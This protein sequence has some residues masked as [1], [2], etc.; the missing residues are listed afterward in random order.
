[1]AAEMSMERVPRWTVGDRL[2]KSRE[3]ARLGVE[4]MATRIGRT[5]N[6][7]TRYERSTT[8]DVNVVRSY[9]A[10]T[11]TPMEWLL[12]G[13]GP[14]DGGGDTATVTLRNLRDIRG[15]NEGF[16]LKLVA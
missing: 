12:T 5:R 8:V 2:R 10:I 6:S 11:N 1:M 9:S 7:V 15:N 4:E 14:E 3:V 16:A 13:Y